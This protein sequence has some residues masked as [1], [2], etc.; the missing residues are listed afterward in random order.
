MKS[1]LMFIVVI[2]ILFLISP[3]SKAAK[4]EFCITNVSPTELHPS[5]IAQLKI[6]V[7]N[8]G[9]SSAYYVTAEIASE[10][11]IKVIGETK[12]SNEK[13]WGYLGVG[14]TIT[15][16]YKIFVPSDTKP[17]VYYIPLKIA[18]SDS[19]YN[20]NLHETTLNFGI[21]IKNPSKGAEITVSSRQHPSVFTPGNNSILILTLRNTGFSEAKNVKISI[22][23]EEMFV[24]LNSSVLYVKNLKPNEEREVSFHLGVKYVN[25]GEVFYQIPIKIY[26]EDEF[27]SHTKNISVGIYVRGKPEV[28][29]QD[30]TIEP[31]TL[32][33]NTEGTLII[34]V[35]NSGTEVAKD[36]RIMISGDIFMENYKFAGSLD[37]GETQTLIFSVYVDEDTE[38]G[39]YSSS[40][41][42][43]YEDK[44]GEE[45]VYSKIYTFTVNQPKA[46]IPPEYLLGFAVLALVI[47]LVYI[48]LSKELSKRRLKK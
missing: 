17:G 21:R 9:D 2:F 24:P 35:V 22:E 45:H 25:V 31:T 5:E 13:E 4:Y 8:V 44:F 18:W 33:P 1:A 47:F 27:G 10:D 16:N 14:N 39:M 23:P 19:L 28:L 36:V 43:I 29:I 42:I 30:V 26:Y 7:K 34:T 15:L 20:G 6:T 37:P 12:K 11:I 38:P 46:F 41:K 32:T 48:Y 3:I 40:I